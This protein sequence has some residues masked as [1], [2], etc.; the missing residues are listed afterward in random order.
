MNHPYREQYT[1]APIPTDEQ[2]RSLLHKKQVGILIIP[3]NVEGFQA[4]VVPMGVRIPADDVWA[5]G[6]SEC[7]VTAAKRALHGYFE[8]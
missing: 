4:L 2:T 3:D 6:K 5:M 7:P 1:P 8:D